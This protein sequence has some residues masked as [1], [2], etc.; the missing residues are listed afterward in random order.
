MGAFDYPPATSL[1][2]GRHP[3]GSDLAGHPAVGQDLPAELP[4]VA[5]VQ[6]HHRPHRQQ[7]DQAIDVQDGRQQPDVAVLG[8]GR[9]GSQRHAARLDGH[10]ALEALLAPVHWAGAGGLAAAGALVLHPSTARW[11]QLQA[12]HPVI[13][14]QHRQVEPLAYPGADPLIPGAAQGSCRAAGI[15]DP[16]VATAEHQDLDEL[17]EDDAVGDAGPV[18]A[19][20]VVHLMGGSSAATWT[21]RGSTMIDGRAGTRLRVTA[22]MRARR[23]SRLVPALFHPIYW[24]S[25]LLWIS[26]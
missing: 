16:A 11:V 17:V 3:T 1:D 9:Q 13:R 4:V 5:G 14:H 8:R 25:L 15:G 24:R 20:R 19:Q 12:E 10:R 18:A 26:V 2:R 21:Q 7:A 22:G 23:S 6:V